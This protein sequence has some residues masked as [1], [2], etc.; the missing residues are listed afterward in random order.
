MRIF[1]VLPGSPNAAIASSLWRRNLHDPLVEMGH[2]TVLWDG[3]IQPIYD[4]DPGATATE[5]VRARFGAAFAAAAE[6][7]HRE[8]PLDLILTYVSDS[9]LAP[10]V[11]D[12][13]RARV[14]PITNFFCNNIH[15]FHLVRR[16][17]PHFSACLVPEAEAIG[18]YRE[19]GANPIFFPMAANPT[20]YRPIETPFVY[21]ASFAGQRYGDRTA[22]VL[23]LNE[24]GIATHA[25]GPGWNAATGG[26][27]AG[28]ETGGTFARVMRIASAARQGRDPRLA[29][30]DWQA[31]TRLRQRHAA[32]LHAPVA[33]EAYVALFSQ[34]RI[35][36]GFLTLSDTH[37]TERPLRQVRLREFE[38]PMSGAFYMTGWIDELARHYE[39][40]REIVCYRSHEEM[41]DLARHYLA[42]ADERERIRRA[43][44][45]RALRDHTWAKRFTDL[46]RELRAIGVL[47][48]DA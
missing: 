11:I 44:R 12:D 21:D 42:H 31:W 26:G 43:G 5:S 22:A 15:Q 9:H 27:P 19:A 33:D 20:V 1:C 47:R 18:A 3:G 30:A 14:A 29:L 28:A 23:A 7:A 35:S 2:D 10:D 36:L 40:G 39:I 45:E 4:L 24:A 32:I 34:S 41:V 8:R 38:G 25:F 6:A 13:V 17:A 16:T 48:A 46:F 37:R